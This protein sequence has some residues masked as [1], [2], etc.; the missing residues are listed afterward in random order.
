M[1]KL[2][3]WCTLLPLFV[4]TTGWKLMAV[5]LLPWL[6]KLFWVASAPPELIMK[7]PRVSRSGSSSPVSACSSSMVSS[8]MGIPFFLLGSPVPPL[9][10]YRVVHA[11]VRGD[12]GDDQPERKN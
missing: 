2:L 11:V 8:D 12:N 10:G 5:L 3:V 1:K 6:R 9:H 4:T 7:T